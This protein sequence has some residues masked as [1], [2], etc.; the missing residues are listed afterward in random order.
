MSQNIHTFNNE[1][2]EQNGSLKTSARSSYENEGLYNSI[3][4]YNQ[5]NKSKISKLTFSE[6]QH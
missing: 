1:T 4:E 5:K 2:K 6:F 3:Q